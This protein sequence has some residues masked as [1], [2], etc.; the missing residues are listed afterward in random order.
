ML[1]FAKPDSIE[2]VFLLSTRAGGQGLN[3]QMADTVIIFDSDFNP[4]MDE[5]AKD[6]VHRIG[7]KNEVRIFRLVSNQTIEEG[8]LSK[9]MSKKDLDNKIIQAGMFN[10]KATD[11]E[12][13]T[14][15][16]DLISKDMTKREVHGHGSGESGEDEDSGDEILTDNELNYELARTE[17]EREMFEKMDA[18]R[19]IAEGRDARLAHIKERMPQI[20]HRHDDRIN[21]RLVC[22]WEV[23][24]W[25]DVKKE[26]EKQKHLEGAELGKRKRNE[27]YYSDII[28][29]K[30]W[31]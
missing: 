11:A 26:E 22:E 23:P 9:A 27:V 25:I 1:T 8:I 3:L 20:A 12:R 17:P 6:R 5:Q 21:Y 16:R 14:K 24:A 18:H 15:L 2:K 10:D 31:L 19:Y 28:S 29:E 30:R 13:S 7:Q 4:Q